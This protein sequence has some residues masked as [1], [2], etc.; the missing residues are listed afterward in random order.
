MFS[1]FAFTVNVPTF[2]I[3]GFSVVHSPPF[4]EYLIVVPSVIFAVA[5][6]VNGLASYVFLALSPLNSGVIVIV[7]A[8]VISNVPVLYSTL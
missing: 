4:T 1:A 8:F 3:L 7:F 6:P 5:P 2:V